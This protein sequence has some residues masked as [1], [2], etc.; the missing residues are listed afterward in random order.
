M[1]YYKADDPIGTYSSTATTA[2]TVTEGS[3]S[4]ITTLAGVTSI[5]TGDGTPTTTNILGNICIFLDVFCI[6][7]ET[8]KTRTAIWSRM[9]V[10]AR[11]DLCSEAHS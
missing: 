11:P 4:N 7:D 8:K 3:Q 9:V 6:F 10:V 5:G 2:G 1:W